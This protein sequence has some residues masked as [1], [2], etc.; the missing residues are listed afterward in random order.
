MKTR[1]T[2]NLLR[3]AKGF[4]LQQGFFSEQQCQYILELIQNYQNH[5]AIT[6]IHRPTGGR[7]LDYSVINGEQIKAYTN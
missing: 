6:K 1:Q 5:H 2:T 7:S 4:R 3:L